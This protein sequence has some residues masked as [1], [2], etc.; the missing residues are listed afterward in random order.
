MAAPAKTFVLASPLTLMSRPDFFT[1]A[2][3]PSTAFL[4]LS[5]DERE[6][7]SLR[8]KLLVV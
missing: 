2:R 4:H 5:W 8:P 6:C 1:L 7:S 3:K